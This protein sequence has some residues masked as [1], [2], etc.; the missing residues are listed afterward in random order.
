MV[1]LNGVGTA[2][3][4]LAPGISFSP[5]A[6]SFGNQSVGTTSGAQTITA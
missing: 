5:A 6:L 2:A 4:V 1:L 3:P